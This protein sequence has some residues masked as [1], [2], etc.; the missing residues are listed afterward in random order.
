MNKLEKDHFKVIDDNVGAFQ[1]CED[2]GPII[3]SGKQ[4]AATSCASIT[5]E[6]A[7]KFVLWFAYLSRN[8]FYKIKGKTD[9][10]LWDLFRNHL[11]EKG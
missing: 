6:Y 1:L 2:S 10:E 8:D 4:T 5:K 3:I 9:T 7:I 11:N